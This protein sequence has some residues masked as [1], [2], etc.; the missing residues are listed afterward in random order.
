VNVTL[1]NGRP[2]RDD[3]SYTLAVPDFLAGGGSGYAMLRGQ[4]AVNTGIVDIDA[5]VNYLRRARQ[6]VR[7]AAE[8]RIATAVA[9]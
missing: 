6:P 4:P 5:F 3:A 9:P 8:P 7:A 1:P 2:L